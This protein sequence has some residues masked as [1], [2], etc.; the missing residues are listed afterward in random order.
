[1]DRKSDQYFKYPPNMHELDLATL[2]SMYRSRGEPRTATPGSYFACSLTQ[3]LI[4]QGKWWFG[5]YYSQDAWD[6]LLTRGSNGFP[7]TEVELNVLGLTLI[8]PG[9][10]EPFRSFVEQSCGIS[11]KLCYLIINDLKQ[12]DFVKEDDDS[13]L[14]ITN[15]GKEALKGISQ[16][17]YDQSFDEE[18]LFV[19]R[20]KRQ[21]RLN[22]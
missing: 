4:K 9:D 21:S 14:T 22:L 12:F 16:R 1:M 20:R 2:V 5:L 3:R 8:Q 10:T 13:R 17:I 7:L 6:R 11:P 19:N 18:M 15:E